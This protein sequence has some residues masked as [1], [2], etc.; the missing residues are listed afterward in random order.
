M[1]LLQVT[2]SAVGGV[3]GI[4]SSVRAWGAQ[5]GM[6]IADGWKSAREGRVVYRVE[7]GT[8]AIRQV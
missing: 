3:E 1:A 7:E 8:A 5:E 6:E 2:G 4:A